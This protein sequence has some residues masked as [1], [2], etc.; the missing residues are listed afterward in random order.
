MPATIGP[1]HKST[2]AMFRGHSED[3]EIT[4]SS[5]ESLTRLKDEEEMINMTNSIAPSDSIKFPIFKTVHMNYTT[6]IFKPESERIDSFARQ[7]IKS[8]LSF[9][10][11]IGATHLLFHLPE[12][13]REYENKEVGMKI[14]NEEVYKFIYPHTINLLLET[15]VFSRSLRLELLRLINHGMAVD[16]KEED[17]L[18][19]CFYLDTLIPYFPIGAKLVIDTAHLWSN[20]LNSDEIV[21][22]IEKYKEHIALIH[23]NGNDRPKYT[24]DRHVAF[25]S[26]MNRIK[27]FGLIINTIIKHTFLCIC[28][29]KD[30]EDLYPEYIQI[31]RQKDLRIVSI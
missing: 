14:L 1:I 26:P 8:Y 20:G 31:T 5:G 3:Q 28:E 6:K 24:R 4:S 7:S 27:K 13:D 25:F 12:N 2:W 16:P 30:Y 18:M 17:Y 29:D 15:P 19:N 9:I 23:L 21:N 10:K 11:L 22:I